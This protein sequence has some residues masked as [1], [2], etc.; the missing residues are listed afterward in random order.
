[1]KKNICYYLLLF[2]LGINLQSCDEET[3]DVM[4]VSDNIFYFRTLEFNL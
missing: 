1:M 3:Y 2:F 4:G